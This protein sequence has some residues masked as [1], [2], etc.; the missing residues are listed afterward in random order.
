[1]IEKTFKCDDCC[2]TSATFKSVA[3]ARAAGW[4]IARDNKT[5]YCPKCAPLHR[6]A[7]KYAQN[8]Q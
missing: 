4:A 1:M 5:C 8:K 2:T 7:D 6:F 3:E